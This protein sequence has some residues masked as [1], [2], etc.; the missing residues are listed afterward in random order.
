MYINIQSEDTIVAVSSP[1]G[2]GGVA[3]IRCSGGKTFSIVRS[4]FFRKDKSVWNWERI[5]Y[6][7]LYY[8]II[9][10]NNDV[11]DEVMVSLF[12]APRSYTGEDM[13]EVYC[14]GS[15]Y[16]QQ[17]ILQ[18]FIDRGARL[19]EAGE[20]TI[21]AY[22]NGKMNLAEAEAIGDI[23]HSYSEAAHRLAIEQLRGG[24]VPMI[25]QLREDI[26]NFASLLELELDFSEEDVEFANREQLM[27]LLMRN[28]QKI[29]EL[30]QSFQLGN[31]IK[32]GVPVAIIGHPNAGKSTLLNALL[33]E[34]KAI[35]SDIPGTTRDLI[36]DKLII[37]GI[38]FRIIDTAGIR[39]AKDEIEKIGIE[40]AV[41]SIKQAMIVIILR[42]VNED[43]DE[44]EEL[45]ELVKRNNAEACVIKVFNKI[46]K[47]E[48][49][50][51][52]GDIIGISAKNKWN[53][54]VLKNKL[55]EAVVS[56]GYKMNQPLVSN[57]RHYNE[58]KQ[59]LYFLERAM[60]GLKER[61]NIELI[62]EDLRF[63]IRHL[64]NITGNITSEDVL[65]NIF[66]KFCIGK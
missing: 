14:H 13:A 28:I 48:M 10:D 42:D 3:V 41:L 30:T 63:A 20:F 58:L 33:N 52:K 55:Y 46:D 1:L 47:R 38:M 27:E 57:V 40:R 50:E 56:K 37:N 24:Y 36:E 12:R 53:I 32:S 26:L 29:S 19:A 15:V 22:L 49:Y 5:R 45:V 25:R 51:N 16:V 2:I 21:R 6:R 8:G 11:V 54:E 44:W 64:S 35:V 61:R 18:M 59:A 4:L 9:A 43:E 39:E 60:S 34:E 17:K 65:K 66:S 31:A 62:A 23:I 7:Y